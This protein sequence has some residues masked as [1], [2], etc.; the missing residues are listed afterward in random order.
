MQFPG[1]REWVTSAVEERIILMI[2]DG[3]ALLIS[4]GL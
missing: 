1:Q 2:A 3:H 4:K